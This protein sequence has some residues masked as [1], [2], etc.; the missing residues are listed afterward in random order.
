MVFTLVNIAEVG[1]VRHLLEQGKVE[2]PAL[3]Q[4]PCLTDVNRLTPLS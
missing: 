4:G 3:Q 1:D 2:Q